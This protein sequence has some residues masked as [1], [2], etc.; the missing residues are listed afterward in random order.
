M[1]STIVSKTLLDMH[2]DDEL[3]VIPIVNPTISREVTLVLR[4]DK[5]TGFATRK[6]I[7]LLKSEIIKLRF[8]ISEQ[9]KKEIRKLITI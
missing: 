3:S 5:F 6:F 2:A 8:P 7:E 1:G 9:S 4:R